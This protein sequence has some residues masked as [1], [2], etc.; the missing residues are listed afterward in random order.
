MQP[1]TLELTPQQLAKIAQTKAKREG[2]NLSIEHEDLFVAEFGYYFGW[3]GVEAILNNQVSYADA[4]T[5][6]IGARK[7][8]ADKVIDSAIFTAIGNAMSRSKDP[9]AT[10]KKGLK[11]YYEGIKVNT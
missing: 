5:L 3:Q 7:V 8:W 6:I 4:R 10:L 2:S 9:N 11:S 1:K